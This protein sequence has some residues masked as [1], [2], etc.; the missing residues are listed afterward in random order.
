[1]AS[2]FLRDWQAGDVVTAADLNELVAAVAVLE[3]GFA[4]AAGS[5]QT[6]GGRTREDDGPVAWPFQVVEWL[7]R[8][9]AELWVLPGRVLVGGEEVLTGA[10]G[11]Q[12]GGFEYV[13]LR[14]PARVTGFDATVEGPQTVYLCL[15]GD[16]VVRELTRGDLSPEDAGEAS[17]GELAG[18][19]HTE[20]VGGK[21]SVICVP[22]GTGLPVESDFLRA[23]PLAVVQRDDEQRVTQL[24]WGELSACECRGLVAE[25][26]AVVWPAERSGAAAW[27]E[28]AHGAGMQVL[29][30]A[31][32]S[33][34]R[35]RIEGELRG[36][37]DVDGA[38]EFYLGVH[39]EL[40]GDSAGVPDVGGDS[41]DD[42]DEP[43]DDGGIGGDGGGDDGDDD[44]G[45]DVVDPGGDDGKIAVKVG[46]EAGAGFTECKLVKRDGT[47]YWKLVL[48][49]NYVSQAFQGLQVPA[50]L[51]VAASGQQVG[52]AA[53]VEMG[54]GASSAN[55]GGLAVTGSGGLVFHGTNS[56]DA[57]TK[58]RTHDFNY[59]VSL[60]VNVAAQ[61]WYLTAATATQA[62]NFV[63]RTRSG[64]GSSFSVVA[65]EWWRFD[66]DLEKLRQTTIN[67]LKTEFEKKQVSGTASSTS[68]D[69]TVT[70]TLSG[71][72]L[73]IKAEAVLA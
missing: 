36:C 20:L 8:E 1:M 71:T 39:P 72:A 19:Q 46:Y 3:D 64:G 11:E 32:F 51:T 16:V 52:T 34:S 40:P 54:L 53:T 68:H 7:G 61:T 62:G 43:E 15:D 28:D 33:T 69:S 57:S 6:G 47:Y 45:D 35:E 9:G 22:T 29:T 41:F 13:E 37:V 67:Q 25:D 2:V 12:M 17:G 70:G 42:L 44:G 38:I 31:D 10:D 56:V 58:S 27:G 60:R 48:D 49:T 18:C 50:Q 66:V 23:W 26:G 4:R 55:A 59:S 73:A 24:L 30:A 5:S 21:L 65:Q 63:K 14:E